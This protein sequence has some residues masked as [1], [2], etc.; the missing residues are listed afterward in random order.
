MRDPRD[1]LIK[2]VVSEKSYGLQEEGVYTFIVAPNA[3]KPEIR[4]AVEKIFSVKVAKVN[5]LNRPGKRK[6]NR[7]SFTFGK[8]ADTKRAIVTLAGD[9]RIEMF[10]G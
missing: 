4:D 1:V 2:P 6:R 7:R 5:T 3:T 9:D 8:R 10:E